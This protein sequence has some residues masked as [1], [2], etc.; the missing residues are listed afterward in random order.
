MF[1]LRPY[2]RKNTLNAYNPFRD[3]EDFERSFFAN[4]F[5]FF[6]DHTLAEFKTDIAD[7]GDHY[8]LEADL[9]G[10]AKEDIHL[11]VD[12]DTL[13]LRA[14]RHSDREDKEKKDQY[15]HCERS[16]G[17]Y[18]R[19]FDVSMVDTAKITAKYDNGVLTLTLP[20]KTEAAQTSHTI[21]I[22]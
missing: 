13:V 12:G 9:P 22:E 14:E 18:S 20:K 8:L 1:E 6:N 16:Y 10:F 7:K 19:T 2:N 4:P 15:I 17:S 3:M 11:D 5:S 21:A